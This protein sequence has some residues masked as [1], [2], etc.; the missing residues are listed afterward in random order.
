VAGVSNDVRF[1]LRQLRKAP[2]FSAIVVL[3]LAMGIGASTAIFSLV[4]GVLLRPLP[5]REPGHL[6][7][8][9][10]HLRAESPNVSV[11]APEI[12]T[13]S[14]STTAFSSMG[15]YIDTAFELSGS[16][17]PEQVHVSRMTYS[18]WPTLGVE[19]LVGR[20]FTQKEDEGREPV[21]VIGYALWNDRY[22]RD[23]HIVGSPIELERREYTIIGVMPRSFEFPVDAEHGSESQIWV[24][25][26]LSASDLSDP[27]FWGYGM[28][29][30]MKEGVTL[31]QARRDVERVAQQVMAEFPAGMKQIKIA[32]DALPLGE[33][34]VRDV[35]PA[36][37][38]LFVAVL[39]V[40]LIACANVSGLLLVRAIRRRGEYAV[41]LALGAKAS[42]IVRQSLF[43]G[44]VLSTTGGLL[45]LLAAAVAIRAAVSLLPES[46]PRLNSIALDGTV[47]GFALLIALLTGAV[48]SLAPAFA[49]LRTNLTDSL[50]ETMRTGSGAASHTWLRSALVIAETAVALVL[51]TVSAAF[52][53]SLQKMQAVDPGF[54]PEHV[55][56][57]TFQLPMRQYPTHAAAN[58]FRREI[59][60]RLQQKPGVVS[61]AIAN[62]LPSTGFAP[63]SAYT[64]EGRPVEGWKL[65]F[66]GFSAVYGDYFRSMGIPLLEGRTFTENDG[67]DKPLVAIVN[68]TMARHCWPGESPLGKRFH[69]G[70]PRRTYP[71]VTVVGVVGDTRIGPRDE[72]SDEQ[73]YFP[74]LQ[75]AVLADSNLTEQLTSRDGGFIVL[76][77]S[78]PPQEMARVLR[79]TFAEVD[80][81]LALQEVRPMIDV[82]AHVEAPRRFNT[83]LIAAFA[84]GALLLAV[85]G[86]Y[87]VVAFS[88][89]QRAHEL[90]IRMALGAQRTGIARLVMLSGAKLACIGCVLGVLGS[91]AVA[92]VVKGF[93]FE[94]SPTDPLLYAVA[95]ALMMLMALLASALPAT[96]A[97]SAEPIRALRNV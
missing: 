61:A 71:W 13:Y 84:I 87:A 73:W 69:V 93:L 42:A 51:V 24:P 95:V 58:A 21:A 75:P 96:R 67:G 47:A 86:I 23:P 76:R 32:G 9:G 60:D 25:L 56:V 82:M 74:A 7:L 12:R 97:A 49:A 30:R 55:L 80:P 29:A 28:L 34:A 91:V 27:G 52:M 53:R 2:G 8:I 62:A 10:D 26:S 41:R 14:T 48:C 66:A 19:P 35:R 85:T 4:E 20:V 89:S 6:V 17:T 43:E 70:N 57:G 94:V 37:R 54:R 33:H 5:L 39:V 72:P 65:K 44:V 50:K 88:V 22:H 90:A 45:G 3:T 18:M 31:S 46:M 16:A 59:V 1:A 68:S 77:S 15:A 63:L 36:L 11:T 38:T 92:R 79:G 83:D 40:L 78:L 64:L 81:L